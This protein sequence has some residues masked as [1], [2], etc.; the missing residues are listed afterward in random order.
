MGALEMT[1]LCYF[2]L[3]SLAL[4]ALIQLAKAHE[5]ARRHPGLEKLWRFDDNG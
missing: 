1:A 4:Y 2:G 3:L 5:S